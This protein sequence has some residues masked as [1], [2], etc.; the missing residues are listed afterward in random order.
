M[1]EKKSKLYRI[2]F[3]PI[4]ILLAIAVAA[5][6]TAKENTESTAGRWKDN[7]TKFY[8]LGYHHHSWN[9]DGWRN[10]R[11]GLLDVGFSTYLFDG[12]LN[13][14]AEIDDFDLRY[15]GS[16]N[17]NLHVIRHRLPIVRRNL[18]IEYGLTVSWMQYRFSNDFRIL[19]NT[20][21]FTTEDDGTAY[22][23]NKL[24]TTF[25]NIPLMLTLTPSGNKSFYLSAGVYGG[26]LVGSK[27]KLRTESGETFRIR[28]DFNL[29]KFRYGLTGRIGLGP[30]AFYVEL[31]L[32]D[33]FKKDQGP[34]LTPLNIGL[35]LLNF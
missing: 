13:L 15:G 22:R 14:P 28:D 20:T 4:F 21:V 10:L 30:I 24:K 6:E 1:T 27:Q 12:S 2:Y 18:S 32:N 26:I 16:L 5:Q 19:E 35:S 33:L 23:K 25:L 31:G 29:N 3:L 34:V 9:G 11:V 7:E 17:F 8:T